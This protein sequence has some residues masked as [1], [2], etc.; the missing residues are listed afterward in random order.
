MYLVDG[1]DTWDDHFLLGGDEG[2]EH[3]A[4]TVTQKN[5]LRQVKGL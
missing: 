5:V 2:W 3:K 1:E 4:R